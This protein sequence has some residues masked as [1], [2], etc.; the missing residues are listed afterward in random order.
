MSLAG[1]ISVNF[2]GARAFVGQAEAVRP[3]FDKTSLNFSECLTNNTPRW[4]E[5]Q[6]LNGAS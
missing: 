5:Y 6:Q 4:L 3:H 2:L 1:K